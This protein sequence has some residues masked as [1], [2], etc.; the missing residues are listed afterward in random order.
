ML[1]TDITKRDLAFIIWSSPLVYNVAHCISSS[2]HS[3]NSQMV[4]FEAI[5]SVVIYTSLVTVTVTS[6]G[7]CNFSKN[8]FRSALLGS[9]NVCGWLQ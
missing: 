4:S 2:L 7:I 8:I 6:I 1:F 5:V 9:L 3:A